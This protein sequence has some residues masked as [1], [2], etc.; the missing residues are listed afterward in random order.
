MSTPLISIIIPVL[1]ETQ[2]LQALLARVQPIIERFGPW[3]IVF[4]DD[5]STDG[6]LAELKRLHGADPRIKAISFSRNFGKEIAIA[7]GLRY[8]Q[9][10]AAIIM[11]A[12]LQHPPEVIEEFIAKWRAGYQVVYGERLDRA[13]DGP[14]R[15]F[16]SRAFYRTFNA[17]SKSDIPEGA[18]DFRLLDRRAIDAMNAL[19]ERSRF[20]KGLFSWIGFRSVGVP[21]TVADR[22]HGGSRWSFRTLLRF[23]LDGLTSFTTLPL[24]IWSLLGLAI[25][26][27]AF[28][29]ALIYLSRTLIY[30]T[31]VPGFP[32]LIISV[33][34]FSGVQLI[35]LGVLGEYLGRV[36]EEVKNR[37]L[38]IVAEEVGTGRAADPGT[39]TLRRIV[40]P[41]P[42]Q[43]RPDDR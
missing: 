6:T 10:A 36:Y 8:V 30:G 40:T 29:S 2:G 42:R 23:A 27:T 7:A 13:T 39:T 19:D 18:G 17:L 28:A 37:P 43:D 31:D 21:Y 1:N 3:E 9:G 38:C 34:I 20:N 14:I 32:S 4:I 22:T 15:R 12:D 26:L 25:S 5:G 24:R 41:M 16:F 11:D 35:S 33:M